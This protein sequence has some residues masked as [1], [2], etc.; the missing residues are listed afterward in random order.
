MSVT[1][2]QSAVGGPSRAHNETYFLYS[3][4]MMCLD[5]PKSTF[6]GCISNRFYYENLHISVNR[7]QV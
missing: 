5:L 7:M 4:S 3:Q 6:S 2:A 1:I